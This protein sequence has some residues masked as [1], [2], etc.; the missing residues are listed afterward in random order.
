MNSRVIKFVAGAGKTTES[1]KYMQTHKNGLYLA[2]NNDVV[3]MISVKGLLSKT[4]DAFFQSYLIPKLISI[5]PLIGFN[6]KVSYIN[7][8]DLPSKFKGVPNIKI[9]IDGTIA[10]RTKNTPISLNNTNEYLQSLGDF[11]NSLFIKYIFGKNELRLTDELRADLSSYLI[12][13]YPDLIIN[14]ID[15]RFS[16]IIIDEAQDLKG[17]RERFAKLIYHSSIKLIILGDENQNINAGGDWFESL[18]ADETQIHSCRC[19]DTNCKWIRENLQINIY[20]NDNPS[21][22][23]IIKWEGVL[24]LDD[25]NRVLIYSQNAGKNKEIIEKWRGT[26]MTIKSAKGLTIDHDIVIIGATLSK[27]N[28]YTAITRTRKSVYSTVPSCKN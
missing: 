13:N 9:N 7:I 15:S 4:I 18:S 3:R 14:L 11:P 10:N 22:F 1:I 20:G 28:L 25:G 5:I 27:K 16:Y 6:K 8:D 21:Q 12:E 24:N 17:Y 26:K 23:L 19:P 2:F